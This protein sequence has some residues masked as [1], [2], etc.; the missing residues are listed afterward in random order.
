VV[1]EVDETLVVKLLVA[2]KE[3]LDDVLLN[4][5]AKVEGLVVEIWAEVDKEVCGLTEMVVFEAVEEDDPFDED[6]IPIWG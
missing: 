6:V 3:A 2:D 1:F 5:A 4:E